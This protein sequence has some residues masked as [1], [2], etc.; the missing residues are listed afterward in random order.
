VNGKLV[1]ASVAEPEITLEK[2]LS[3]I[4]EHNLHRDVFVAPDAESEE[5]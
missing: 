3:D 5:G 2:L 4:N 1:V